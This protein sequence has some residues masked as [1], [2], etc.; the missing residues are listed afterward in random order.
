[1]IDKTGINSPITPVRPGAAALTNYPKKSPY[2]RRQRS[3]K[4]EDTPQK[5]RRGNH[6]D[7]RC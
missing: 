1:M 4:E 7:E 2:D 5:K 6:V 3:R